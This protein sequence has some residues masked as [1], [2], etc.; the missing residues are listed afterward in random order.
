MNVILNN[1]CLFLCKTY[2]FT[3]SLITDNE[4]YYANKYHLASARIHKP[5]NSVVRIEVL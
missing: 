1:S 3:L 4:S 2:L 5:S